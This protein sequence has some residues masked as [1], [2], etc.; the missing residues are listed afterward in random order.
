MG[1]GARLHF[2]VAQQPRQDREPRCIGRR[3]SGR[4]QGVGV[5]IPDRPRTRRRAR[6]AVP[7][8]VEL[9]EGA[10]GRVDHDGVAVA[11]GPLTTFNRRVG[12]EGIGTGIALGRVLERHARQRMR[13]GHHGVGHAVGVGRVARW[14]EVGMEVGSGAVHVGH[15]CRAVGV[16]RQSRDVG[17]PDVVG[18]EHGA[19][20]RSGHGR[21]GR[22]HLW[23]RP[24]GEAYT[25]HPGH[26][27][28]RRCPLPSH[29][30][31]SLPIEG[32]P[33]AATLL[34][35]NP[36]AAYSVGNRRVAYPPKRIPPRPTRRS[37]SCQ[38][39]G[40]T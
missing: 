3:P 20:G 24:Q 18:R 37:V 22:G 6:G 15:P 7:R 29:V 23:R 38:I 2:V 9:V 34:T 1:D 39:S 33:P 17:V 8:V 16:D 31:P 4:A 35:G 28:D 30:L 10:G 25:Q 36:L 26:A 19:V 40:T 27:R 11:A 14:T 32:T 5:E 12:A 13:R 21:A